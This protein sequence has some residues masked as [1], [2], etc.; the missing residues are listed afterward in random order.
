MIEFLPQVS[1]FLLLHFYPVIF[2]LECLFTTWVKSCRIWVKKGKNL[3][4]PWAWMC[5][6]CEGNIEEGM[7]AVVLQK[8]M[9]LFVIFTSVSVWVF[10]CLYAEVV[11]CVAWRKVWTLA[12][13]NVSKVYVSF[14]WNLIEDENC[15]KLSLSVL[16]ASSANL[17]ERFKKLRGFF[18]SSLLIGLW[19]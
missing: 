18:P 7:V 5:S 9:S 15:S 17:H 12:W 13:E 16:V 1:S 2:G 14:F 4:A 6:S 3:W 11:C 8:C 10:T 19:Y